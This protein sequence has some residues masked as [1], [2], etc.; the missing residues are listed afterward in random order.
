M[1]VQFATHRRVVKLQQGRTGLDHLAAGEVDG[2]DAPGNLRR[3]QHLLIGDHRADRFDM[4]GKLLAPGGCD[5]HRHGSR[6]TGVQRSG[7]CGALAMRVKEEQGEK[8][9]DHAAADGH[10]G[11]AADTV[12]G[13]SGAH[14]RAPAMES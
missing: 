12:S 13:G 6:G 4:L 7:S 1:P 14:V 10:E 9:G 3:H 5:N 11:A 2:T 8:Y